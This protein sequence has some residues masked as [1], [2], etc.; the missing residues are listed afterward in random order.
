M[1]YV[2]SDGWKIWYQKTGSGPPLVCTGGEIY[3][4]E[5]F[6]AIREEL[7]RHFTVIDWNWR[8]AG[9]S[10][11]TSLGG[12]TLDDWVRDLGRVVDAL[13]LKRAHFW[14][15]STGSFIT[16]RYAALHPD[17]VDRLVLYPS[18]RSGAYDPDSYY[19]QMARQGGLDRVVW[20]AYWVATSEEAIQSG[21]VVKLAL[22]EIGFAND[23]TPPQVYARVIRGLSDLDLTS[24]VARL[25]H[26]V[27]LLVG[28]SGRNSASAPRNAAAIE[29]FRRLVPGTEVA[30]IPKA[31]GTL[32]MVEQPS[33]TV[34]ALRRFLA[35]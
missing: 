27:L 8:G 21:D 7:A 11:R 13:Q 6:W 19:A 15:G 1:P 16:I 26:P 34:A 12:F 24:D 14:G 23:F 28:G 33:A 25:R 32:T 29:E 5:Q 18:W 31:G 20:Q 17:R 3:M 35:P 30:I 9:L 22:K 10:D 4:H 2:D